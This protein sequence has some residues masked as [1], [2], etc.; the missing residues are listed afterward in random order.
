MHE[1]SDPPLRV[2]LF[3]FT[4]TSGPP[5]IARIALQTVLPEGGPPPEQAAGPRAALRTGPEKGAARLPSEPGDLTG[6]TDALKGQADRERPLAMRPAAG[7]P[8]NSASRGDP[9]ADPATPV[10]TLCRAPGGGCLRT[11]D[12]TVAGPEQAPSLSE[13]ET[14]LPT[15]T[16]SVSDQGPQD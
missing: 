2:V 9:R 15:S 1:P 12:L 10:G 5:G 8:Q 4:A 16:A 7:F 14:S 13:V 6:R 3:R 11:G